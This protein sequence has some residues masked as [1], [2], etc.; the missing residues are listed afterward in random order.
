[1]GRRKAEPLD[2]AMVLDAGFALLAT[3]GLP[4]LSMRAL[5]DRLGVQAP[6][7]YWHFTSKSELIGMMAL[8]LYHEARCAPPAGGEW[9]DW[10]TSYG[11]ALHQRLTSLRDGARL[12]AMAEPMRSKASLTA[13]AIAAPLTDRGLEQGFALDAIAS[14]TSLA[15]GWAS[16]EANA[17]MHALLDGMID[18]QRSFERG[19]A[20]LVTGLAGGF[21]QNPAG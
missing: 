13:P 10:L 9:Q 11:R 8:A 21:S 1:M 2:R 18:V 19:L 5:A 12:C 6:A 7:L 14:V 4:G 15:L 20:A 16:F 17:P 3:D